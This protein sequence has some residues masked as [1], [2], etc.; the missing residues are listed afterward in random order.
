MI[1][2]SVMKELNKSLFL[3]G[4]TIQ[5]FL[6]PRFMHTYSIKRHYH[7]IYIYLVCLEEK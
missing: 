3:T 1:E 4:T 7:Q 5:F 2:T 6:Y